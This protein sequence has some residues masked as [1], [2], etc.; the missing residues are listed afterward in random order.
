MGKS[1]LLLLQEIIKMNCLSGQDII[2]SMYNVCKQKLRLGF[3]P[4]A[5]LLK[6]IAELIYRI[7]KLFY[8]VCFIW[9]RRSL[10]LLEKVLEG[11]VNVL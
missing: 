5:S 3:S 1:F 7:I 6:L 11:P 10:N 8:R 4:G 2:A 9:F